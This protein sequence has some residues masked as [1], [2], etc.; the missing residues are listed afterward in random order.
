MC[1]GRPVRSFQTS[2][3]S[4]AAFAVHSNKRASSAAAAADSFAF[5]YR[6]TRVVRGAGRQHSAAMSS[7]AR[8]SHA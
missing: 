8:P 5:R 4:T 2:R 1:P 6:A 7:A 3:R